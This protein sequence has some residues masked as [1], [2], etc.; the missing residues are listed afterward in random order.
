MTERTPLE[1]LGVSMVVNGLVDLAPTAAVF[2]GGMVLAFVA[3]SSGLEYVV[4]RWARRVPRTG[5]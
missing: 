4:A 5:P 1:L 3:A 2:A